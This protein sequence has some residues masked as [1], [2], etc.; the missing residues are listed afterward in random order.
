MTMT[1]AAVPALR[2]EPALADEWGPRIISGQYD[3]RFIPASEKTGA[4]IGM[5]MTR[6]FSVD[7]LADN[8]AI[9]AALRHRAESNDAHGF[10]EAYRLYTDADGAL[11]GDLENVA[12][13]TLVVTGSDDVGSTP[14]MAEAM[15]NRVQDGRCL[16]FPG[17]RHFFAPSAERRKIRGA[18]RLPTSSHQRAIRSRHGE[19]WRPRK[20]LLHRYAQGRPHQERFLS[21]R[22][23]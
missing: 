4:T 6:W 18:H 3:P 22:F 19:D 5:A 10:L 14:A 23:L 8:P 12:C 11:S 21:P 17:H 16:V 9:E 20:S 13:P 2:H 15:A 1:Y 7:F